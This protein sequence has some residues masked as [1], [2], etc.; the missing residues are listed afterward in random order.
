MR[1]M[2]QAL[3]TY[4]C[5]FPDFPEN[6]GVRV[7]APDPRQAAEQAAAFWE[8]DIEDFRVLEERETLRVQVQSGKDVSQWE[9]LGEDGQYVAKPVEN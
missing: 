7:A 4:K 6:G 1:K 5:T 2:Q 8:Q 3:Q 9:V